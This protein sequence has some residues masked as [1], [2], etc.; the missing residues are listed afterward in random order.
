MV[1]QT[2]WKF[3]IHSEIYGSKYS[4][5]S[6]IW[7]TLQQLHFHIAVYV[8]SELVMIAST[9]YVSLIATV[10]SFETHLLSL[11]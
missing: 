1:L 5:S 6:S 11:H 2:T 10:E 7:P 3:C 4:L 9:T 8:V